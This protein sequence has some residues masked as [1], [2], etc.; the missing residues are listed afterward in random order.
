M[1][2][3]CWQRAHVLSVSPGC[4]KR[5]VP[6]PG[7]PGNTGRLVSFELALGGR[8]ASQVVG[9][10]WGT[11]RFQRGSPVGLLVSSTQN[12]AWTGVGTKPWW[13]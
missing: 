5:K 6:L 10:A 7:E 11:H 2:V 3:T 9:L 13:R 1:S 12:A 8:R 4:Q